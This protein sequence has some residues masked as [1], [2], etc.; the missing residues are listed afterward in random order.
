MFF[1][2]ICLL[3]NFFKSSKEDQTRSYNRVTS[4]F[5]FNKEKTVSLSNE[6]QYCLSVKSS[7]VTK[8]SYSK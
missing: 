4:F 5:C 7:I 1:L 2:F 8:Y 6:E 3:W